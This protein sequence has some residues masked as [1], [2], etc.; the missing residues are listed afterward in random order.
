M[1]N[2][3]PTGS[4]VD[5]F[6]GHSTRSPFHWWN[7]WPVAQITSDG[8]SAR[9]ADR[10]AHS[11]LVWGIPSETYLMYGMSKEDPA[12]LIPLARS[13]N[14]PA[15]ISDIAGADNQGYSPE[16]R[17]WHLTRKGESISIT[18]DASTES[19]VVNPCFVIRSWNSENEAGISITDAGRADIRQGLIWDTDGTLTL[20]VWIEMNAEAPVSFKITG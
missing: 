6:H 5:T 1:F 9:A 17:A 12:T 18:L 20:V 19:P 14:H 15:G 13:W 3:Y 4:G 11:S 8:R 10:A 16:E 7:H 2:I